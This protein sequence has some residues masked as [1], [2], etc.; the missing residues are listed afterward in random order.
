MSLSAWRADPLASLLALLDVEALDRDLFLGEPEPGGEG[1]LFGGFVASQAV[2]T[3]GRTVERGLLHSLH[4][5]FL[6]PG[7][8][9]LPIRYVVDR[10]REGRTFTTRRVVAHQGGE[11]I[12]NLSASFAV[13]E[14]GISHQSPAPEAP[15]PESA[16]DWED[17]RARILGDDSK[18]RPDGA[19]EVRVCDPDDPDPSVKLPPNRRVWMRP[20]GPMPDDPLLH[21]AVLVYA[22]DRTLLGTAARPHGLPWGRRIGA[23]LDHAVWLHRPP[24]F[25]DW[26][27]YASE[28]PVAH[29][30]R[31]LI[32]GAMYDRADRCLVSVAQEGLIRTPRERG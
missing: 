25:D 6:R 29:A 12:F 9:D 7:R 23:S 27:L 19:I 16:P 22:T 24:K 14:E 3:A 21:A 31:G 26:L 11:A 2:V 5:Y 10:I 4:A 20:R 15:P 30:A 32:F 17:E 8:H 28:S 1:P 13:P 18:R